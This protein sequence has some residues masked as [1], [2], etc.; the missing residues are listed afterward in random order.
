VAVA[1]LLATAAC[2]VVVG[3]S[4]A[5][6]PVVDH[7]QHLFRNGIPGVPGEAT[8]IDGAALVRMLDQAGIQKAVVLS[9]AYQ[10]GNPNR[11][12]ISDEY[13]QVRAENDWTGHQVALSRGR[14]IGFCAL[15]PLKDYALAELRRCAADPDLSTGIKLHFGN[16]DVQLDDADHVAR[17]RSIFAE[18]DRYCMAI[19]IHLHPSV[20]MRRPWGSRQARIFLEDVLPAAPD[21]TVQIAHLGGAGTYDDPAVD[22]ALEEFVTAVRNHDKRV[23]NLYFDISG[24][25]GFGEWRAKAG[26]I[27]ARIRQL[28]LNHILFGSDG[29]LPGNSP[30]EAWAAVAEL[31]LS[32]RELA[33]I[34]GNDAPYPGSCRARAGLR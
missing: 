23:R 26:Q 25:A 3:G 8:P 20:T 22:A 15:D 27:V 5:P 12:P 32:R 21:V 16:S 13:A 28:G 24:I 1:L 30:R 4:A 6:I 31:P 18:A 10:P 17:L 9:L 29:A 7:H 11:P 19:V 33:T 2:T 34:A 14:L